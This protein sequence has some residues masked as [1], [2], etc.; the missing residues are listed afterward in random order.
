MYKLTKD[1][2]NHATHITD[3]ISDLMFK[4]YI[5]G[6]QEHQSKLWEFSVLELMY[7]MRNE[8]IDQAVYIQTAIDKYEQEQRSQ[9]DVTDLVL[10]DY[11]AK[12]G[13]RKSA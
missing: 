11:K 8:A 7:E 5:R 2:E 13:V 6:A 9:A 12:H 10:E 1:H 3:V 4:K